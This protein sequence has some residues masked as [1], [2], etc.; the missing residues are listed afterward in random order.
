MPGIV[1]YLHAAPS[2]TGDVGLAEGVSL[3]AS[4]TALF[5]DNRSHLLSHSLRG[6]VGIL[7]RLILRAGCLSAVCLVLYVAMKPWAGTRIQLYLGV[8][9]LSSN[10]QMLEAPATAH[11]PLPLLQRCV[12]ALLYGP[13]VHVP[14]YSRT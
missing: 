9:F 13:S 10:L 11:A 5:L 12:T 7:S 14:A 8:V 1:S 3:H 2:Q 4:T 6:C